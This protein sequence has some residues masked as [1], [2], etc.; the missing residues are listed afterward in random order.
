MLI[1]LM[2]LKNQV[3]YIQFHPVTYIV[4]LNIE[5]SMASLIT[6][7]AKDTVEDR[8]NEL[9]YQSLTQNRLRTYTQATMAAP[10]TGGEMKA[11]R[12]TK[13][14]MT[15]AVR[16]DVREMKMLG[17]ITVEDIPDDLGGSSSD[18]GSGRCDQEVVSSDEI[19]STPPAVPPKE[20]YGPTRDKFLFD[21]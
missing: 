2:F 20:R 3:V 15:R 21:R 4:K 9:R 5:M 11:P 13:Y 10:E 1:C 16:G 7:I 12:P 8:N 17:D 14:A 6:K 18:G 19:R